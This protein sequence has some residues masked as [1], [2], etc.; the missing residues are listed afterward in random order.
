MRDDVARLVYPVLQHGLK[1]KARLDRGERPNLAQ[2]QGELRRLLGTSAQPAPFGMGKSFDKSMGY[3]QAPSFLGIRYA[4]ACWLDELF[5]ADSPWAREWDEQKIEPA[6]F[7]TNIRYSNFWNQARQAETTPEAADAVEA[8]LM[9]V[10]LGFRGELAEEKPEAF[11]EWVNAAKARASKGYGKELA[12]LPE[13]TPG[14]NVP[15]LMGIEGYRKM[16]RALGMTLLGA[17]LI[18]TF[19]VVLYAKTQF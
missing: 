8:F 19:L 13:K 18:G 16:S 12:P 4:L 7:E 17:L 10:L 15:A 3:D 6:L 11:R 14:S 1:L 2:E 9:C 5:I